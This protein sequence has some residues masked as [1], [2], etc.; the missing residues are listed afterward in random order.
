MGRIR[1][2][3]RRSWTTSRRPTLWRG[4]IGAVRYRPRPVRTCRKKASTRWDDDEGSKGEGD[5][6]MR[7]TVGDMLTIVGFGAALWVAASPAL[8]QAG[9]PLTP[10][11]G[12]PPAGGRAAEV[13][14]AM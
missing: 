4:R 10:G 3:S 5:I 2:R 11:G 1:A 14:Q 8:A 13:R 7:R 12:A 6:S 9:R